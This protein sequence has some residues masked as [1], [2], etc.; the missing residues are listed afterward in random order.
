MGNTVGTPG[1]TGSGT[2]TGTVTGTG[3]GTNSYYYQMGGGVY[4]PDKAR[5]LSEWQT[6]D[7]RRLPTNTCMNMDSVG[8]KRTGS[9][10]MDKCA[11]SVGSC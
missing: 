1:G 8:F 5:Q 9:K 7:L 6:T 10:A 4:N 3:T 2:G 11:P